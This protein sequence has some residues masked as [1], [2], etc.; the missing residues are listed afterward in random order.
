MSGKRIKQT[1]MEQEQGRQNHLHK[2]RAKSELSKSFP[3]HLKQIISPL[4]CLAA[5]I[6]MVM[7]VSMHHLKQRLLEP[8]QIK[9]LDGSRTTRHPALGNVR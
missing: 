5:V 4:L 7:S 6:G 2:A 1:N 9:E 3:W 8:R